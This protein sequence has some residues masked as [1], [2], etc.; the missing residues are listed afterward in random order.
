MMILTAQDVLPYDQSQWRQLLKGHTSLL[1]PKDQP[2]LSIP[3][4][5]AAAKR[6]TYYR[7][8]EVPDY[9]DKPPIVSWP[10]NDDD[11]IELFG[12]R[13]K[14]DL[15]IR[16]AR[17]LDYRAYIEVSVLSK[18]KNLDYIHVC[19]LCAAVMVHG[20]DIVS[21]FEEMD[22]LGSIDKYIRGA[23]ALNQIA[24]KYP[25]AMESR[26][27]LAELGNFTGYRQP[28]LPGFD[29]VKETQAL[30]EAGEEHG[31][32]AWMQIFTS[33]AKAIQARQRV[34]TVDY[35]SLEDFI[36]KDLAST[37][38]A[39]SI[40]KVHYIHEGKEHKFKARKNLLYDIMTAEEIYKI[41]VTNYDHQVAT[42]FVK[43]ELGKLRIAVTGD[44]ENYYVTSW[45]NYLAGHC[46][47][48]W[49]GN[50][51]EENSYQQMLRME[52]MLNQLLKH[53]SI[54]FDF[55]G[56][57]HQPSM[58]EI[59][60]L[61]R[62][63]LENALENVPYEFKDEVRHIIDVV[64]ESFHRS[65]VIIRDEH[66][67]VVKFDV[68][69][70]VQSG[71]RLT[72][73]LGNYW[74]QT[75][76]KIVSDML[77][78]LPI[79]DKYL[80][81]DDSAIFATN[82]MSCLLFRLG[83]AALNARGHDA[84]YGIHY[85]ESEFLRIWYGND[86]CYGYPNRAIPGINQR[87]P[88]TSD[89]WALEGVIEAQLKTIQTI[90]RRTGRQTQ[91]LRQMVLAAWTRKRGLSTKWLELPK[92][93]GGL[94]ILP[95]R[96]Y[97]STHVY[98]K[99]EKVPISFVTAPGSETKYRDQ[100]TAAVPL[101]Q[102]TL[103]QKQQ[104]MI[105]Q[106]AMLSKVATDDVPAINKLYR[107]RARDLFKTFRQEKVEWRMMWT[108]LPKMDISAGIMGLERLEEVADTRVR[109]KPE[110]FGKYRRYQQEWRALTELQQYMDLDI[111][112]EYEK[113]APGFFGD[114]RRLEKRGM[115]RTM[116]T[117]WLFGTFERPSVSST[118]DQATS[119]LEPYVTTIFEQHLYHKW[120]REMLTY[121]MQTFFSTAETAL[122]HSKLYQ[123]LLQY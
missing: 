80:R 3:Q 58:D 120:G 39:S 76:T 87:K 59:V 14:A 85:Q 10:K 20:I 93:M 15:S 43:P 81:G 62:L 2:K 31:D 73:L 95:W 114:R 112:G 19:N 64:V 83:Y 123:R 75:I 37:S 108:Q 13:T 12:I 52:K 84:K 121:F 26:L 17:L 91:T 35:V 77:A 66:G 71:I 44:I 16:R 40:G 47:T 88:W 102:V 29:V 92:S 79:L 104:Q 111:Q 118:H 117:D 89:P 54:P 36:K 42:A 22:M 11:A 25:L 82:Y 48:T 67:R 86:R 41:V 50:T 78:G 33:A 28:P 74:N 7:K 21:V 61:V 96:G 122:R 53:Y 6:L 107:E 109:P 90:E 57:D 106:K 51:L 23:N 65:I 119:I 38:G 60:A 101:T 8:Y 115:H 5:V 27:M 4:A 45:L 49:E 63:Y 99:I 94:G 98:P 69:G 72:S 18:F 24:K 105:Q 34:P 116:A 110:M 70:G 1:D 103:T 55:A 113:Y 32:V 97:I 30:A 9:T 68:T 100:L 56:F 46:Y